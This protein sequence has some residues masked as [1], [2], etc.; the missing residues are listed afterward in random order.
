VVVELPKSSFDCSMFIQKFHL[1]LFLLRIH[2]YFVLFV[3]F[4]CEKKCKFQTAEA[5]VPLCRSKAA[6]N[7]TLPSNLGHMSNSTLP[8]FVPSNIPASEDLSCTPPTCSSTDCNRKQ[9]CAYLCCN[10]KVDELLLLVF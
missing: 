9:V 10:L 6:Y 8:G 7:F 4:T 3:F 1:L 2:S 5:I